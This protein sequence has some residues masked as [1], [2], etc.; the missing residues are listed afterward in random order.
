MKVFRFLPKLKLLLVKEFNF[1]Y[2]FDNNFNKNC[3]ECVEL[4]FKGGKK[5]EENII[6]VESRVI[7][8]K[9]LHK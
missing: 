7:N 9:L 2:K 8:R 3:L 5:E 1:G 6:A 4:Q